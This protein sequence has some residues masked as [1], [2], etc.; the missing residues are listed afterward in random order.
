VTRVPA[1]KGLLTVL[2]AIL[3]SVAQA[4]VAVD[5]NV[6][7]I[8]ELQ[9]VTGIGPS[10]AQRIVA[11]RRKGPFKDLGDLEQRV[12]GVGE[13]SIRKMAAGGLTVGSAPRPAARDGAAPRASATGASATGTSATS[14]SAASAAPARDARGSPAS[15]SRAATPAAR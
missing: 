4:R 2:C 11:E 10:I 8:D 12:R 7:S 5:A 13:A 15:A 1:V 3:M 6:A 14:A 9:T